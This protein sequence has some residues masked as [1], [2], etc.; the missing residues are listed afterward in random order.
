MVNEVRSPTKCLTN[1]GLDVRKKERADSGHG[2]IVWAWM[3]V[4]REYHQKIKG[5]ED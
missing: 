2:L 3:I 4:K 1:E 5:L